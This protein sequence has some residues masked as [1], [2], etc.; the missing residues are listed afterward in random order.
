MYVADACCY[1]HVH[2]YQACFDFSVVLFETEGA[3][4]VIVSSF[5]SRHSNNVCIDLYSFV[6]HSGTP[7]DQVQNQV[8]SR[9]HLIRPHW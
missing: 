5:C 6:Y 7:D 4:L 1:V 3:L 2:S 9:E 8:P